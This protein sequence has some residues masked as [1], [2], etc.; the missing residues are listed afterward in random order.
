MVDGGRTSLLVRR[1]SALILAPVLALGAAAYTRSRLQR[2][3]GAT[4]VSRLVI[5]RPEKRKMDATVLAT[6]T[7]R[8]RVGAQVRVGA[9]LSGTVRKLEVNVGSHVRKGDV[10]A[11]IDT[12]SVQARIGQASAQVHQD[13][14][15]LGKAQRDLERAQRLLSDGLIPNQ[16]VEDFAWGERIAEAKLE[17]ARADLAAARVDLT[18]AT[19]RAPIS[20]TVS[21]VSTQEGETVAASFTTPTFVTIVETGALELVA[22]VDEVDIANVQ[23]GS[24]VSFTVEAYPTADFSGVVERIHPTAT[25]VSGVVNYEVVVALKDAV[26]LLKPDMTASVSIRTGERETL[27]IPDTAI[28]GE[29]ETKFV[30]VFEDDQA[31]RRDVTTGSHSGSFTEIKRGLTGQERIVGGGLTNRPKDTTS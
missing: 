5:I 3:R 11:E 21:A 29:G 7:I 24:A 25:I 18:Y 1:G 23:P 12:T 13:E 8:L 14:V 19:I 17:K 31:R 26:T 6:G 27:A 9:Q 20:G 10:I 2:S 30:Y 16:Q 22:V 28:H 15:D 4:A